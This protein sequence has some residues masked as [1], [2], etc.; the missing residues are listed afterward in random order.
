MDASK[1]RDLLRRH[2]AELVLHGHDHIHSVVMLEG[3]NG[4]IPALGVPSASAIGG[5]GDL[6]GY[7]LYGIAKAG[8]RWRCEMTA[9]GFKRGTETI[10]ELNKQ[11]LFAA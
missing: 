1:F 10:V 9:R 4:P 6:A 3:P 2:G 5:E 7:N 8:N 11:E